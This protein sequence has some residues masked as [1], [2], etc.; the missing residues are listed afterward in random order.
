M[1]GTITIC[2]YT[3]KKIKRTG[4]RTVN[5]FT[6]GSNYTPRWQCG[7]Y[8]R[9]TSCFCMICGKGVTSSNKKCNKKRL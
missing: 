9:W 7:D 5:S 4:Y 2:I 8:R 1:L 3:G 6:M